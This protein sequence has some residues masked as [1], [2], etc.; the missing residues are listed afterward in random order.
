MHPYLTD[1]LAS[2]YQRRVFDGEDRLEYHRNKQG[3]VKNNA[4]R[5]VCKVCNET[6]MDGLERAVRPYLEL[7]IQAH[8]TVVDL[9]AQKILAEYLVMKA[10][11][12][13]QNAPERSAFSYCERHEFFKS[14]F[15]PKSVAVNIFYFPFVAHNHVSACNKETTSYRVDGEPGHRYM[16]NYTFEFRDLFAQV[17]SVPMEKELHLNSEYIVQLWPIQHECVLWPSRAIGVKAAQLYSRLLEL[18]T[19]GS[20]RP[21]NFVAGLAPF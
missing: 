9:T 12:F 4:V 8:P 21:E 14:R 7:M 18:M 3:P 1:S 16:G 15:I 11:V 13:D 10:M 19:S 17:I 5:R 2:F 6:W 20:V